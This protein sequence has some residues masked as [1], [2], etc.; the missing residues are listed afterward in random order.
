M[1]DETEISKG[2]KIS[3]EKYSNAS[4][5]E[6]SEIIELDESEDIG[7]IEYTEEYEKKVKK[8][9][10]DHKNKFLKCK[11]ILLKIKKK[12]EKEKKDDDNQVKKD[13]SL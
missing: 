11:A 8:E 3:E 9:I 13:E 1:K 6:G 4:N 7:P 2:N 10:E 12:R 5:A